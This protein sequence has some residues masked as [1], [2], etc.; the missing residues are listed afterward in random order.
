M[1]LGVGT[2]LGAYEITGELGVGG[3][4]EVYRATD[5]NLKRDVA[6]KVL[7]ESFAADVDRLARFRR[8]AEVLASL[9]HP[10]IAQI[11]GLERNERTTALVMELVEGPTLADRIAEG[12][13]APD[14]A[15]GI[16]MQIAD[17]LEAAHEQG[18]VH[19]DL[20]PANIKLRPDGTVKVLDFG[21]AKALGPQRGTSDPHIPSLTTPAMTE[22]EVLLGTAAYMSP[23]QAR[24]KPV[25]ERADI[26]AFGCVLYEMLTGQPAFAGEDVPTTLAR[27][28]ANEANMKS[29]P[30][31]ISA[32]ARKA[33]E[34]CLQKDLNRR[35]ADIRDVKLA[36]QG[37][38]ETAPRSTAGEET[39]GRPP[40]RRALP[41]AAGVVIAAL[42]T[43]LTMWSLTRTSTPGLER[44][45]MTPDGGLT[46]FSAY[47]SVAVSPD[48][49]SI[50]YAG[51]PPKLRLRR[52]DQLSPT[53]LADEGGNPFFS[54]DGAQIGFAAGGIDNAVLKR[55]S[56]QGGPAATI[57]KLPRPLRGAS[58]GPDGTIIYGTR[59]PDSGLWRVR[60][61]GG[62]P[63]MLTKPDPK[64]GVVYHWW[65]EILP[66][67][68][69][70]LF[71]MVGASEQDSKI[72]VLSLATGK[73]RVLLRGGVSPH[74]SP[75]GHLLFGRAGSLFAVR[76]DAS[77]SQIQG[78]PVPV[79]QGILTKK[80]YATE[81]SLASNGTLLYL[82][83]PHTTAPERR[84]VWVDTEGHE[85]PVSIP[86]H[87]YNQVVLSP[88]GTHAAL[89]IAGDKAVWFADL[90][91]GRLDRLPADLGD[92][93]P[94]VLFFSAEGRRVASSAI[95]GGRQAIVWQAIDG[96]GAA[97]PLVTFDDASVNAVIAGTLSPDGKRFVPTVSRASYDLGIVSVG[98][99]K[100]YEDFLATP[101]QELGAAISPDGHWIAY[102]S[103]Q[104]GTFQVYV[105]R[106]PKG[107]G[108][109]LVSTKGGLYP[110]WSADGSALTYVRLDGLTPVGM[111]RVLVTGL[112]G[113]ERSPTFGAP[114]ELFPWK[115]FFAASGAS[116]FDATTDGKRFLMIAGGVRSY[117]AGRLVLVQ[118][119]SEDLK[120]LLPTK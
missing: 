27:V 55:V 29:L 57:T 9:N 34:L 1:A 64:S 12:P 39:V 84:L 89:G 43:G 112:G 72:A 26:W 116:H 19:R 51:I 88:D 117:E 54:P 60:A 13:I 94:S 52:L 83:R 6:I 49:Q 65:P 68:K 109:N 36:L 22:A 58:W 103:Y 99:P 23:E 35:I 20:K 21:I 70:V 74:Y 95:R 42:S 59:D 18:I 44:F 91:R 100:S 77:R 16:A 102:C 14:D 75:T 108:R 101:S 87:A 67:G 98:D 96:T 79:Q 47:S 66:D 119:W 25:D 37:M 38:F 120:R 48:G 106:F 69:A 15:L 86:P 32:D 3:M 80:I 92:K 33:I 45:D 41:V 82:N 46:V 30:G 40:W 104:M 90:K 107:G 7:P 63:E 8:E 61:T 97:E 85:T 4:G 105:Q 11:H 110:H 78:E 56:I 114:K 50:V 17:A 62:E 28:L 73:Q 31:A 115:Y 5:T 111:V 53:T 113:R 2:R 93:E 81:A 76:F 10:N 24:G 71:T 118:N